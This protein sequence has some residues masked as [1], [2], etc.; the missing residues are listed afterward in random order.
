MERFSANVQGKGSK[1]I[2]TENNRS[3]ETRSK[4]LSSLS[5]HRNR[6]KSQSTANG[7]LMKVPWHSP[8]G[9]SSSGFAL[10][11]ATFNPSPD[12]ASANSYPS[13]P[14]LTFSSST[15][16]T[17]TANQGSTILSN[18]ISAVLPKNT[19]QGNNIFSSKF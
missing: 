19:F 17:T 7:S 9:R 6:Y 2:C 13:S 3:S 4:S 16:V 14:S 12:K 11:P 15:A 5:P 8:G 18:G 1:V 10:R